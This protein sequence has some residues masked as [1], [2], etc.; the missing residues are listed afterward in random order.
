MVCLD[1]GTYAIRIH[2]NQPWNQAGQDERARSS[3]HPSR[4]GKM[5]KNKHRQR[6]P[7]EPRA[8]SVRTYFVDPA[9]LK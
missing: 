8:G 4:D 7:G 5:H 2:R 6:R 1:C 3:K 9:T